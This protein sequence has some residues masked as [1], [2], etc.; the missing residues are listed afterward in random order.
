MK[1]SK[2]WKMLID[3][4]LVKRWK[5]K[6]V[7]AVLTHGSI[8]LI[9]ILL[10][11]PGAQ[12]INWNLQDEDGYSPFHLACME[13]RIDLLKLLLD[14]HQKKNIDLNCRTTECGKTGF[15]IA[16]GHNGRPLFSTEN[17]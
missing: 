5:D 7:E 8:E 10:D 14:N 3:N 11:H 4:V 16:C 15:I 12:D 13:W 2:T 1:V 6:V 17:H 9:Q